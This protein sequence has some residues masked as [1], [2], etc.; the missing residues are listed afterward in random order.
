LSNNQREKF[1]YL[2]AMSKP[3]PLKRMI[4]RGVQHFAAN[5]GPHI[6]SYRDPQLVVL[7][8]HRILPGDDERA[9]LEEPGMQVSPD[10]FRENLRAISQ[11]FNFIS[12]SEWLEHKSKG[13]ALPSKACAITFDDGWADNFE[14]AFPILRELDIPATIFLVSDMIGTAD[15]FWPERLARITI[16]IARKH[17]EH[18]STPSL[19]W[20]RDGPTDFGFSDKP[21]T[22]EEISQLIANAKRFSDEEIHARLNN[23]E[24]ELGLEVIA[25][26]PALLNWEQV[27]EMIKSGLVEAGSHTCHHIRLDDRTPQDVLV[28]EILHSKEVI[29]KHTGHPVK[30]FCFPNGDYSRDALE[31][32]RSHYLGAVTTKTGWN[33]AESDNYLLQRIGIHEDIANDK[34]AF[35]AR[36]SG[37]I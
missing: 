17:P 13:D 4:K 35:L 37:W 22:Q 3:N 36:V 32:V 16:A 33:T 1:Q 31:L 19:A 11:Q 12:L 23:I 29:E 2:T 26:K 27:A 10:T 8:Y 9:R 24:A 14:F 18:W 21:P 30:T 6:R 25:D 15:M 7:M 28:N 34:T 20:L 5:L